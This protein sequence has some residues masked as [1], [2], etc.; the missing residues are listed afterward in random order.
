MI[1][2]LCPLSKMIALG[3]DRLLPVVSADA[4]HN[5]RILFVVYFLGAWT[6]QARKFDRR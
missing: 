2:E 5:S 3:N 1:G 6:K 4:D